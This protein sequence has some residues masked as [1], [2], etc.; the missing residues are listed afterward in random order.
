MVCKDCGDEFGKPTKGNGCKNDCFDLN[1]SC[2][3]P[4]EEYSE[5]SYKDQK[6]MKRP[7]MLLSADKKPKL[8]GRFRMFKKTPEVEESTIPNDLRE[9]AD[10]MEATEALDLSLIH[11]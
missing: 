1:A 10:L 11:I 9:I 7:H 3:M 2:W 5:A 6:V 4:K 8:D